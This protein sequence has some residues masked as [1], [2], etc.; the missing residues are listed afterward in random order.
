MNT[1][2]FR[3]GRSAGTPETEGQLPCPFCVAQGYSVQAYCYVIHH[4]VKKSRLFTVLVVRTKNVL[5]I[6]ACILCN[7]GSPIA[8]FIGIGSMH[9]TASTQIAI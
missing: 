3:T 5:N 6:C 7:M 8:Y 2:S 1:H 4:K 9:H